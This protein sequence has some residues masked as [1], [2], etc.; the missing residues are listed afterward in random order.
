[1]ASYLCIIKQL[2]IDQCT[3]DD[4]FEVIIVIGDDISNKTNDL[5]TYGLLIVFER[6]SITDLPIQ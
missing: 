1:M 4:N 2:P 6:Y 3:L 5:F